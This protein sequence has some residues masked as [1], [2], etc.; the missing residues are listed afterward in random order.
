MTSLPIPAR[1]KG[2]RPPRHRLTVPRSGDLQSPT[3]MQCYP[4]FANIKHAAET[5]YRQP[6]VSRPHGLHIET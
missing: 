3:P 4:D 1:S 6:P 5:S 2:R